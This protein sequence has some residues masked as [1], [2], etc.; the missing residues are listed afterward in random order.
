MSV[1]IA[2]EIQEKSDVAITVNGKVPAFSTYGQAYNWLDRLGYN[3]GG[4]IA[5]VYECVDRDMAIR[6]FGNR[7]AKASELV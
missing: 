4:K 2:C 5:V 7:L 1:S 6:R 3:K